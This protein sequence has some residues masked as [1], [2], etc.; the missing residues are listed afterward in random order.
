MKTISNLLSFVIVLA[1]A[2]ILLTSCSGFSTANNTA[3]SD[4][5]RFEKPV[6]KGNFQSDEITESS[7]IVASKCQ[8]EVFWTHNDSGDGPFIFA[9]DLKGKHL[10]VWK[11]ANSNSLDWEDMAT[12]KDNNGNCFLY[13]G[14]IGNTKERERKDH[15]IYRVREPSVDQSTGSSSR[16][17]P[18][19]SDPATI[20]AFKYPDTPQDSETLIVHPVSGDIY[21]VTKHR[22]EPAGVFLVTPNFSNNDQPV[23]TAKKIGDVTVPS[24]PNGFI[25]GG[26]ISSDGKRVILCDYLGGYEFEL[27]A[28][29]QN[30]DEIWST[31]SF[32]INLGDRKQGEAI[33]YSADG[34]SVIST[35]EGRFAPIL[36]VTRK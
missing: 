4:E 20:V 27:A 5:S 21:L 19:A 6:S 23:V 26:D 13:M 1:A 18:L 34:R 31:Q 29:K 33:A 10:G 12:A 16:S 30:L 11:I 25:T 17:S 8:P 7:G 28:G 15:R 14:D 32:P 2:S 36:S 9:F 35:S 3:V 24:I 22:T